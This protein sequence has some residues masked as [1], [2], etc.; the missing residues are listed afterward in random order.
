MLCLILINISKTDK[1]KIVCELNL[2]M[3]HHTVTGCLPGGNFSFIEKL[4]VAD[5]IKNKLKVTYCP[6]NALKF[7]RRKYKE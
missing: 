4:A 2:Q 7:N 3:S 1:I 5:K 6:S